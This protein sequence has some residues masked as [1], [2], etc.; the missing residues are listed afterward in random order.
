[1]G[2]EVV[3]VEKNDKE[4][5][6]AMGSSQ[7]FFL[8]LWATLV[9]SISTVQGMGYA[10]ANAE[11]QALWSLYNFTNGED[12]LWRPNSTGAPWSFSSL[13][14]SDPCNIPWQGVVCNSTCTVG[15]CTILALNLTS[16]GLHGKLPDDLR[17]LTH[18]EALYLT[19]NSISGKNLN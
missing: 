6:T 11:Y 18:L 17:N 4:D 16:Y 19:Y 7:R 3:A 1:M 9:V 13:S 8:A 5:H 10:L 14:N 12:W 15:P 2:F